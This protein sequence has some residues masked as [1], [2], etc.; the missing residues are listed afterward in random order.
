MKKY[1]LF[2][3]IIGISLNISAQENEII[4]DGNYFLDTKIELNS[5][6]NAD[7]ASNEFLKKSNELKGTDYRLT[8]KSIQG[9]QVY[10]KFWKFKNKKTNK[11][12]NGDSIQVLEV[13]SLPLEDFQQLV[14]PLY[15]R[16]DWRV[17]IYSVPFK[18]RFDDFNFDSNV[19]LGT[20]LG[21]KLRWNRKKENGFSTEFILGIGLASIKL[22]S[23]N[24]NATSTT[25]L[26]AFTVNTGILFHVSSDI[27]LGITYGFDNLSHNDQKNYDWKHNGNGWLGIGINVAFSKDAKN[28]GS[29]NNN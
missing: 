27:N 1:L 12:I 18:L 11:T 9:K 5:L 21:A 19:N 6:K 28:T 15:D 7:N 17:G 10:F 29:K 13:Y 3:L 2:F 14:S 24:S 26:S 16:I 20:N 8:V 25:N 23:D 22:D 4:N